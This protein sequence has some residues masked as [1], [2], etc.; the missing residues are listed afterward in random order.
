MPF[1]NKQEHSGPWSAQPPTPREGAAAA[2]TPPAR[3]EGNVAILPM[4]RDEIPTNLGGSSDLLLGAGAEFEG[5]LTFKGTV[6]ID[7]RFRGSIE[8]DDVL[9][10]GEHARMDASIACGTVVVHGEVNGD[11][12]AKTGV[13]LRH[14]AKVHGDLDTPSL[15]IEK[16][17]FLQGAVRMEGAAQ[18]ATRAPVPAPAPV[19]PAAGSTTAPPAS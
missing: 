2:L 19:S 12:R 3:P 11:I 13:E 10:V 5:K 8:T 16:G 17:A 9:I 14:T 18:A 4:K 7:A 6:R 1:W 15:A